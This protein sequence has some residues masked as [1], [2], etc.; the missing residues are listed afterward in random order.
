MDPKVVFKDFF[1]SNL[2]LVLTILSQIKLLNT[3]V[4][5]GHNHSNEHINVLVTKKDLHGLN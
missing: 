1:G 5:N 4:N 2:V 3:Y